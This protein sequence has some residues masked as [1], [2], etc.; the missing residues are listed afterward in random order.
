LESSNNKISALRD[1]CLAVGIVINFRGSQSEDK[2]FILENDSEKMKQLISNYI[3]RQKSGSQTSRKG[4]KG[5]NTPQQ[6]ILPDEEIFTYENLP[7]QPSDIADFFPILKYLPLQNRDV[8]AFMQE[9]KAAH[10]AEHYERAFDL[11]S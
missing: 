4:K 2:E 1:I 7:F 6:Q 9:A 5:Q 11:Y 8:S 3:Y 10:S